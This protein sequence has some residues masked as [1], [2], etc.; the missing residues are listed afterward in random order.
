MAVAIIR[1]PV[2]IPTGIS[3]Q[4]PTP[5]EITPTIPKRARPRPI[6]SNMLGKPKTKPALNGPINKLHQRGLS[7]RP[8]I[9]IAATA[10]PMSKAIVTISSHLDSLPPLRA[11][12]ISTV[13]TNH[14]PRRVIKRLDSFP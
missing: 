8:E 5:P 9:R 14:T 7:R 1:T 13:K 11:R 12:M 3:A 6:V 2:Y 4:R 10:K